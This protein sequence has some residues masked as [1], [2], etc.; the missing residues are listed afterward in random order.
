MAVPAPRHGWLWV[1]LLIAAVIL[2]MIQKY[3]WGSDP[4]T[5][6]KRVILVGYPASFSATVLDSLR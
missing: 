5:A 3:P 4:A 1:T 6:V 2:M